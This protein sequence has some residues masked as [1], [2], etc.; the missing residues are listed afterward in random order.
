MNCDTSK[1]YY[2]IFC[3]QITI[4]EENF[5]ITRSSTPC[6][7]VHIVEIACNFEFQQWKFSS[8]TWRL[9]VNIASMTL[10]CLFLWQK[11]W[12]FFPL[13]YFYNNFLLLHVLRDKKWIR[14]SF[15]WAKSLWQ[16]WTSLEFFLNEKIVSFR[17]K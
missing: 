16:R 11:L 17:N 14:K 12:D 5:F 2:K 4:V 10:C 3:N 1:N 8:S 15:L 7:L 13:N 6:L 9:N